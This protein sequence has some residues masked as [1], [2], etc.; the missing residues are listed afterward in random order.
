MCNPFLDHQRTFKCTQLF[1][2][3][4][5]VS[6]PWIF[7]TVVICLM[8]IRYDWRNISIASFWNNEESYSFPWAGIY[9]E[10]GTSEKLLLNWPDCPVT[11]GHQE[12]ISCLHLFWDHAVQTRRVHWIHW[13]WSGDYIS[14]FNLLSNGNCNLLVLHSGTSIVYFESTFL[15]DAL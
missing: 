2:N 9:Q 13:L 11:D 4:M 14:R 8:D 15:V 1:W 3:H 5:N 6:W 7:P 12:N 10:T